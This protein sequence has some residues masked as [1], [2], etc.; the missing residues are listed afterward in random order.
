MPNKMYQK[1][2]RAERA[3]KKK[4]ETEGFFVIRSAGSKGKVDIA[5]FKRC[6][7]CDSCGYFNAS[8]WDLDRSCDNTIIRFY[9]VKTGKAKPDKEEKEAILEVEKRTGISIDVISM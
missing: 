2:A 6:G 5:A 3:L 1:G 7:V 8:D 9:Q 4:L